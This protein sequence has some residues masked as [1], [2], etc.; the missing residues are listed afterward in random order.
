M[1]NVR[2]LTGLLCLNILN[3]HAY[4]DD[5]DKTLTVETVSIIS[6]YNTDDG[7]RPYTLPMATTEQEK[8]MIFA[9]ST[10]DYF[11]I[12]KLMRMGTSFDMI[13]QDGTSALLNFLMTLNDLY[14]IL[15]K[16]ELN[17]FTRQ[18]LEGLQNKAIPFLTKLFQITTL[19]IN[20][21]SAH[22]EIPLGEALCINDPILFKFILEQMPAGALSNDETIYALSKAHNKTPQLHPAIKQMLVDTLKR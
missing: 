4:Q 20:I 6:V 21:Q 22:K 13:D 19:S 14:Q 2:I 17:T 5:G 1:K 16:N 8:R 3:C 7:D 10:L 15:Q 18:M 11:T 9:A 12:K